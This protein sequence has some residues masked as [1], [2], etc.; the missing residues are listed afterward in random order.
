[1]PNLLKTLGSLA[2]LGA[3][4]ALGWFV[5]GGHALLIKLKPDPRNGLARPGLLAISMRAI[6]QQLGFQGFNPSF[7]AV[8]LHFETHHH[9]KRARTD[10]H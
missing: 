1:M 2:L 6:F 10:Q 9:V 7:E 5:H 8:D 3:S 4:G